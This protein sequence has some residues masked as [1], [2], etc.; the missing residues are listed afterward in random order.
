MAPQ[1]TCNRS[2]TYSHTGDRVRALLVRRAALVAAQVEALAARQL[3]PALAWRS[4]SGAH[5]P[6]GIGRSHGNQSS[7]VS[8]QSHFSAMTRP[9]WLGRAVRNRI[10]TSSSRRA[11]MAWRST[12]DSAR[13]R[14]KILIPRQ[15]RAIFL[16]AL[17]VTFFARPVGVLAAHVRFGGERWRRRGGRR[18]GRR[19]S[20]ETSSRRQRH[21]HAVR[22]SDYYCE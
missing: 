21:V 7:F 12:R 11:S 19:A 6:R 14:H 3:A 2:I 16:R 8:S 13:T 20:D 15:V 18:G 9:S 17:R 22:G 4:R 10:A 5:S 1:A